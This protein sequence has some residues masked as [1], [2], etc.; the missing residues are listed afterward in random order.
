MAISNIN[1]L[2]ASPALTCPVAKG[3]PAVR[4]TEPSIFLSA[5]SLITQ[6]ALRITITPKVNTI[7]LTRLGIPAFASH[8]AQ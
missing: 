6:P 3:R 5:K 2:S 7:K 1:K 4:L 8:K